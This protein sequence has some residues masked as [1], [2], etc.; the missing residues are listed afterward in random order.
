[1]SKT[2]TKLS[3]LLSKKISKDNIEIAGIAAIT[4]GD[5]I[6]DVVRVDQ[7]YLEGVDFA[8]PSKDLNSV[9]KIGKQNIL[10]NQ[11][12]GQDYLQN[13]H[14]IN[15][16]GY[17][18]EFATHQWARSRGEEVIIPE[19]FNQK[20][21]DALYNGEPYQIKFGSVSE[22][23]KARL[24]NPDIRV[25]SDIETAEAYQLKFPEDSEFVN[26]TIPKAITENIV[27]EGKLASMEVFEND[28]FYGTGINEVFGIAA[29]IPAIKNILYVAND[30]TD[31]RNATVNVMTDT[32][33]ISSGISLG[34]AIGSLIDPIGTF[35][36]MVGGATV[37]KKV[38]DWIKIEFRCE[39]EEQ[40]LQEALVNYIKSL[41]KILNNNQDTLEKKVN[42]WKKT[43]GSEVYRRKVLREERVTEELYNYIVQ[44]MMKEYRSKNRTL[45]KLGIII[46]L[47]ADK[48]EYHWEDK[49][50][51]FIL[52][53]KKYKE[54][55]RNKLPIIASEISGIGVKSGIRSE[56]M[57][58]ETKEVLDAVE[59][60]I[61]ALKKI[62]I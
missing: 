22:I 24:E 51:K 6:Y 37:T 43:F 44:R 4:F 2:E 23:R 50:P 19:K 61:S 55:S 57:K 26:G 45:K 41:S 34:G 38:W 14:D 18:H 62:G 21:Y 17:T 16:T 25:R 3:K 11:L 48:K 42:K 31:I 32:I 60:Y 59:K 39:E 8:R 13:L 10:D 52:N 9:F 1:M 5:L 56:F 35:I 58:K 7:R 40:E 33:A 15:Y 47:D 29:I 20:G 27:S 46:D 36:G 12:R 53:K 30:K 49:I 54:Y 28:E